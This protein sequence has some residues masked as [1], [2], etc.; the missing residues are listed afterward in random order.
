MI[1]EKCKIIS[2][3][4]Q[5]VF[6][7]FLLF[8]G[9]SHP[10]PLYFFPMRKASSESLVLCFFFDLC[11]AVVWA[12]KAVKDA[13]RLHPAMS[14]NRKKPLPLRKKRRARGVVYYSNY[15]IKPA[16]QRGSIKS[17]QHDLFHYVAQYLI[18]IGS[19]PMRFG[20]L[21]ARMELEDGMA[22]MGKR[23]ENSK[24]GASILWGL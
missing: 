16:E 4:Q 2:E 24:E 14:P 23:L 21:L 13:S 20:S 11:P 17:C 10:L 5:L 19:D 8:S 15:K 18:E 6:N 22:E 7:H 12:L 3:Q 9:L 1:T